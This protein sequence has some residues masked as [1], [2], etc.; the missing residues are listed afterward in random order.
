MAFATF[1]PQFKPWGNVTRLSSVQ[2]IGMKEVDT[3]NL[4]SFLGRGR[5]HHSSI[6]KSDL[7]TALYDAPS[8]SDASHETRTALEDLHF[9]S[10]P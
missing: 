7:F 3:Y 8:L 2:N 10:V 1:A 6:R 9:W 5:T 4:G